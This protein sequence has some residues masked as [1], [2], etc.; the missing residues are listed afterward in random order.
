MGGDFVKAIGLL[1]VFIVII[2]LLIKCN[3]TD[4]GMGGLYG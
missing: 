1:L 4:T 3:A 2:L